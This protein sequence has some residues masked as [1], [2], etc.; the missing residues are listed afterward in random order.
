MSSVGD[1]ASPV[2]VAG[3]DLLGGHGLFH[4]GPHG[5]CCSILDGTARLGALEITIF[6]IR[7]NGLTLRNTGECSL[8]SPYLLGLCRVHVSWRPNFFAFA[9]L[10]RG[11]WT[12]KVRVACVVWTDAVMLEFVAFG[13]QVN[14]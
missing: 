14:I 1:G 6:T 7:T 12:S 10:K 13:L 5:V 4:W 8:R 11:L 2:A 9:V 3:N